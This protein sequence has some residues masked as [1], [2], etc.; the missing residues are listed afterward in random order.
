M[1]ERICQ[2]S[3]IVNRICHNGIYNARIQVRYVNAASMSFLINSLTYCFYKYICESYIRLVISGTALAERYWHRLEGEPA[4]LETGNN[5]NS[6]GK[7]LI[8]RRIQP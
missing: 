4:A 6:S 8:K 3:N 1:A 5:N 7:S 2:F